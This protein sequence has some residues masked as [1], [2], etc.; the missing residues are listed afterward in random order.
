M[1]LQPGKQLSLVSVMSSLITNVCTLLVILR[2]LYPFYIMYIT[3]F[4]ILLFIHSYT[5]ILHNTNIYLEQK[6]QSVQK[7][8][9]DSIEGC[10][11]ALETGAFLFDTDVPTAEMIWKVNFFSHLFIN[12]PIYFTIHPFIIKCYSYRDIYILSLL[13]SPFHIV[14]PSNSFLVLTPANRV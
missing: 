14:A 8:L 3:A 10:Q 4:L 12:P 5:L 1:L 7:K 13:P 2:D 11:R 6:L 9:Q